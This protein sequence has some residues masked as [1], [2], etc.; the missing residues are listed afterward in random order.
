MADT[1]LSAYH[2]AMNFG[3]N[4]ATFGVESGVVCG[5]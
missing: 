4:I 2:A 5:L 3:S 1:D